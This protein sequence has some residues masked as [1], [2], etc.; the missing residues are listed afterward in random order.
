MTD[1]VFS[2]LRG[3]N[4]DF[5]VL[6][7]CSQCVPIKLSY[8]PHQVPKRFSNSQTV[9]RWVPQD[10][11]NSTWVLSHV[12]CPKF[13]SPVY[14]LKRWKSGVHICFYF[15]TRDP[16]RCFYCR[17]AQCCKKIVDRPINMAPKKIK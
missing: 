9:P 8:S 1:P 12:V 2:F 16:K 5:F 6:F 14:K 7:P 13:N 11:P 10:V 15:A 3:G 17:H 4:S